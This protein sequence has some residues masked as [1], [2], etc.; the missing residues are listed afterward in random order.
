MK[1]RSDFV[2]NSSSSSFVMWGVSFDIDE[3]KQN[4]A[5]IGIVSI[6]EFDKWLEN[7]PYDNCIVGDYDIVFG[8][9]PDQMRDDE[10]L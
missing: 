2:S 1:V 10:T 8:L 4:L 7:Q 6:D 5:D 3:L 9:S